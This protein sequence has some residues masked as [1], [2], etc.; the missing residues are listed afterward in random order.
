[1]IT[2]DLIQKKCYKIIYS[3]EINMSSA[4][5]LMQRSALFN[6]FLPFL[7]VGICLLVFFKDKGF[8]NDE[9]IDLISSDAQGYYAFL[10]AKFIYHDQDFKIT[11]KVD[12][13]YLYHSIIPNFKVSDKCKILNKYCISKGS[14][15][16]SVISLDR[17]RI[18]ISREA[19]ILPNFVDNKTK[20]WLE[21]K[22]HSVLQGVQSDD[23]IKCYLVLPG[24]S[25]LVDN[26]YLKI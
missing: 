1:M 8:F 12:K 26:L 5:K 25:V 2:G 15:A 9:K 20:Q 3:L 4:S 21:R 16:N 18:S 23:M 14:K 13:T 7:I 24:Y 6:R 11:E 17:H 10:T 19:K 22:Y